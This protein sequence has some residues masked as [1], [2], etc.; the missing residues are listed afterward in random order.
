[1]DNPGSQRYEV[2]PIRW[3]VLL[4]VTLLNLSNNALWISYASVAPVSADYFDKDI[5]TDIDLLSTISFYVGIPMCIIST[6]VVDALGFKT[7]MYVGTVLTFVGGGVR[8]LSTLPGLNQQMSQDV[9]FYLSLLGQALT[10]MGNPLAVSLPTKVSQ[11][12]FPVSERLLATGVLAMSLPLGIVC[13][14]GISPQFVVNPE[15][16]PTMNLV[17]FGP[18]ALT[19]ICCILFIRS[20]DPPSPPSLSAERAAQQER[21]TLKEYLA[22]MKA[23]ATNPPYLVLFLVVG[24]AVGFFNAFST[25]LAKMMCSRGYS[26]QFSGICGSLL[27]GTGFIGAILTGILVERFGRME[28][29]AKVFYGF[30]GIFGI[31]I[32]EF[33]RFGDMGVWIALFASSFGV[34]G[35]GMYPIALELSVECTYPLDESIGT[36]M[37]FM[38]GQI[39]GG[40]LIALAQVL[41][42]PLDNEAF[43]K[44]VCDELDPENTTA[45]DHTNF[46]MVIAGYITALCITFIAGFHAN[47]KR[48][49]A[50]KASENSENGA[51]ENL[52]VERDL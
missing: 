46:L 18:A 19:M 49:R 25:Q 37:I 36:A 22:N 26:L 50:N 29:V 43:E 2:Y 3:M 47:Y 30:A 7:G 9:Q 4:S 40:V 8:A 33:M 15:D 31:L 34:F 17:W 1:M 52:G 48:S 39:Q 42:Q 38:S 13:G 5:N 32:A 11:N 14:Q 35:F 51:V 16:V 12:W 10:G 27:L 21:K 23:V 20:S 6:Y 45:R 28:E 41:Q 24:G 44:Q